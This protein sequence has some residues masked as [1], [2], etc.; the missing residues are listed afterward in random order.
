VASAQVKSAII[1]AGIQGNGTTII[2]EPEAT[3]DHTEIMINH[4]GGNIER[5]HDL[6]KLEGGQTLVGNQVFVPGD[7]SS[8]AFLI[9]LALIAP[10][11]ELL[12]ENLGLNPTRTGIMDALSSMGANIEVVSEQILNGEKSGHIMI[13]NSNL[14]GIMI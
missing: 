8:A 14:R 7:I 1:L 13:R 11:G 12:I 9:V 10:K 2:E 6:I 5:D 3:R 4:F